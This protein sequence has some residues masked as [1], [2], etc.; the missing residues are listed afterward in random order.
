MNIQYVT[1]MCTTLIY[2]TSY[3]SKPEHT[4]G[5]L[6]KKAANKAT[7]WNIFLTKNEFLS[8]RPAKRELS[9]C[10]RGSS[11][12]TEFVQNCP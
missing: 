4:M 8:H 3:L 12:L 7:G 1:G 2:V 11:I 6:M 9:L 10:M 5:E